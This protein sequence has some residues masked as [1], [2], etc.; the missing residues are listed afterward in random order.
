[1]PP[2]RNVWLRVK[3][4]LLDAEW[5]D[6][7]EI[8]ESATKLLDKVA[9][10]QHL[11]LSADL[12]KAINSC[13][14]YHL[15]GFRFI[16]SEITPVDSAIEASA[17]EDALNDANEIAGARHS[18]DRAVALISDRQ[19]PD[20]PNSVKESISAVESVTRKIA[21]RSTLGDGVKRLEDGGIAIHPALK[22][23]W[24]KLYGWSSD[25]KGVRHG[26]IDAA[27][28]DQTM[29]KYMLVSCAAFV[30]YL[31]EEGRKAKLL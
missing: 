15:V 28:V 13:F 21:G 11:R 16:E 26:S 9:R 24:S 22:E 6:A 30:S 14:E 10:S 12:R 2:S 20:Y 7:L 27:I 5:F 4:E 8:L 1:M 31:I 3:E 18:L 17:I 19:N 25:E 29:A 23:G